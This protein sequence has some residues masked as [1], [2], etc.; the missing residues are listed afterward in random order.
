V[1]DDHPSPFE[2][3]NAALDAYRRGELEEAVLFLRGGFFEN[4]YVAPLLTG[5]ECHP[6]QIQYA[7]ADGEPRAAE[8]YVRRYRRLW[9]SEGGAL[10]FLREVWN[11]P[12]V[13]AELRKFI[14]LSKSLLNTES[15]FQVARLVDERK[16]FVS[17]ERLRRTQ[18]EILSRLS[19][20]DLQLP[21]KRP[22]LGLV[23]LAAR[24]PAA[25]VDFYR[26]LLDVEPGK[27]SRAARGYAE[28]AFEGVHFAIHGHDRVAATDPYR[29]GPPPA[30]FGWGAVFVFVVADF[31]RYYGNA[32]SA[33]LEIIDS[34]LSSRGH[35]FF[36]VKDPS[37]YLVEIT[38]E[39]PEGLEAP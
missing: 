22:R 15:D 33:K 29:L 5:E 37:G 8:E 17:A 20:R 13:R 16:L 30:A 26:I 14:S 4:L 23:L 35:R 10:H 34:D 31:D 25:S 39:E 27:T 9:E 1:F 12:L 11:D 3:F 28:F 2:F 36:V 32:S 19:R 24:D 18:S 21:A 7:G 6:Q 38:E